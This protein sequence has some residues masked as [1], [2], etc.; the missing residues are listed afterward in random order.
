MSHPHASQED[1]DA[2]DDRG[3]V[4]NDNTPDMRPHKNA[5]GERCSA[6]EGDEL[7]H[8]LNLKGKL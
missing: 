2:L 8:H 3:L 4:F 1:R 7:P 5:P 6:A